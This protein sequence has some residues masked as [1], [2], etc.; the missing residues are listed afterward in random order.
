[1]QPSRSLLIINYR[2][3]SLT[4]DAIR[5][6]RAASQ[7]PLQV[8]VVDNSCDPAES[9]ALR[10]V[11]AEQVVIA[12]RNLGYA[13]GINRGAAKCQGDALIVA[14]P[15]VLFRPRSIDLL[16]AA[17]T[18]HVAMSGP[19]FTWDDADRWFL[20]PAEMMTAATKLSE[21]LGA[22]F[23]TFRRMRDRARTRERIRFWSNP[24]PRDV[25]A[26]SG[27]VMC[28]PRSL[29]DEIGPFDERFPLYF[30][31][32]DFMRRIRQ[33]GRA[34]L[35]VPAAICRHLYGQSSGEEEASTYTLSEV[36]YLRKW[37]GDGFIRLMR[38]LGSGDRASLPTALLGPDDPLTLPG[39]PSDY[40]VEV[41]P[42]GRF[43]SAAGHFPVARSVH[44]PGE[45][46]KTYRAGELF[47]RVVEKTSGAEVSAWRIAR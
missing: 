26:L 46:W 15:D 21:I 9:E 47:A 16:V 17:L 19:A 22:H 13:G 42:E 33:S 27:A 34:L 6:A 43:S 37:E 35:Y 39:T 23:A 30:E 20:P 3:A 36:E 45:S 11:D 32:I 4:R 28:F 7:D 1:M 2:S 31:E 10:G 44:I 12:D 18:P 24:S 29:L 25:P 8:V 14:N 5:T 40:L 41:S 38:W